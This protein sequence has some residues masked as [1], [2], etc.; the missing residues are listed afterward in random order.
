M[1]FFNQ[2]GRFLFYKKQMMFFMEGHIAIDLPIKLY[3]NLP[4]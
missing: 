3:V 2:G 4:Y 1:L